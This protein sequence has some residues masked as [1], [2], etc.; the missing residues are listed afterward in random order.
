VT[1]RYDMHVPQ[2]EIAD[3]GRGAVNGSGGGH[4]LIGMRERVA[5]FAGEL[6]AGSRAGAGY[7]VQAR[8]PLGPPRP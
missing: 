6:D 3:S 8:P 1:V 7:A 5:L 4:V 2:L